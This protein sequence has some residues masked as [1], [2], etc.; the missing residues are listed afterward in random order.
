MKKRILRLF[1]SVVVLGFLIGISGIT[2]LKNLKATALTSGDFEID[3]GVPEGAPIFTVDNMAPGQVE[4]RT[5]TIKNNA[6][7]DRSLTLKGIKLLDTKN[8]PN[9]LTIEITDGTITYGPKTMTQFFLDSQ[10]TMGISFGNIPK[11]AVKTITI[12]ITLNPASPNALMSASLAFNLEVGMSLKIPDECLGIDFTTGK[13]IT[14]SQNNDV[15]R[16]TSGNDLIYGLEGNDT[17]YAGTGNDCI[18]T[19]SGSDRVYGELDDDIIV[20]ESGADSI[21]AGD[22][23]DTVYGGINSDII[24]GGYGNDKLYGGKGND[25]INGQEGNDYIIGGEGNDILTGEAGNDYI[26]GNEGT[27]TISGGAGNDTLIGGPGK[28]TV[29]GGTGSD[30]CE[31]ETKSFCEY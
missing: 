13:L 9:A 19:G 3:F 2:Y 7:E 20:N 31:G 4:S 5:G 10:E 17:I 1:A 6:K 15:L 14:G 24:N 28:D 18:V 25:N 8:L 12:I 30:T 21:N 27:D 11:G 16:G 26:E 23:N 29:N 22:G